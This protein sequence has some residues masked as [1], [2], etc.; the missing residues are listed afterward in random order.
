MS[1]HA[2]AKS[3]THTFSKQATKSI[4]LVENLG[5]KD[6]CHFGLTVQH[7]SRLHIRPPPA[8][9]RQVHLIPLEVLTECGVE[10]AE[11]GENIT[12]LGIDLLGLGEQINFVYIY[13]CKVRVRQLKENLL[14]KMYQRSQARVRDYTSSQNRSQIQNQNGSYCAKSPTPSSRSKACVTPVRKLTNLDRA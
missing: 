2:V 8:N 14:N 6:D 13:V 9:L 12:T 7:R 11:I 10:P 4:T 1:V 3:T 5:V